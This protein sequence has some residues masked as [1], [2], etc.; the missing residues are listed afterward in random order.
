MRESRDLEKVDTLICSVINKK[1]DIHNGLEVINDGINELKRDSFNLNPY[2]TYLHIGYEQFEKEFTELLEKNPLS[3]AIKAYNFGLYQS[4]FQFHLYITGSEEWD[5]EDDDWATNN[6]YFPE[7]HIINN[8][9]LRKLYQYW[10]FNPDLGLF[11]SIVSI[12][13]FV[14]TYIN[15]YPEK[16][17]KRVVFATGFDD[18]DLYTFR[19]TLN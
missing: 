3:D 1:M 15:K 2:R 14:N 13:M 4:S 8:S 12:A 11:L 19:N 16:F 9:L 18:G 7:E 10:R 6:D 5:K 17:P